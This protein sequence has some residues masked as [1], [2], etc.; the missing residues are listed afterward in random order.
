VS[1][2]LLKPENVVHIHIS[3]TGG[4][5]LR[6][7]VWGKENYE[8]PAFGG[9]PGAWAPRY[10]FAFVR[11]PMERFYSAYRDFSQIRNYQGTVED[12]ARVTLRAAPEGPW[13]RVC[14]G[15]SDHNIQHHTA[16][17]TWP[18]HGLQHA[19]FIGRYEQYTRDV[20][21]LFKHI[22]RP[23]PAS[24]PRLRET[25]PA[26]L[27]MDRGLFRELKEFYRKDYKELGYDD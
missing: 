16:P 19:N 6:L 12:F 22:G 8:G 21:R 5:T 7:G 4:S 1:F 17:Q 11:H 3:K 26:P 14:S 24:L 23:A 13:V 27:R 18:E 9:M 15:I 10:K 20:V 25:E 2:F